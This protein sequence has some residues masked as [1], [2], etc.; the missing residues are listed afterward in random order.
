[1]SAA[2]TCWLK[3][4]TSELRSGVCAGMF[5]SPPDVGV[6]SR[7]PPSPFQKVDL[8]C[9][10]A[11]TWSGTGLRPSR[12]ERTPR[13][14]RRNEAH[15][16]DA[17]FVARRDGASASVARDAEAEGVATQVGRRVE[18]LGDG[19]V[20]LRADVSLAPVDAVRASIAVVDGILDPGRLRVVLPVE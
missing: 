15:F 20:E 4:L 5:G 17:G 14:Q 12:A 8:S 2:S 10:D 13:F 16:R 6:V 9:R 7:F 1:C 3:N 19:Q 18:P 11:G